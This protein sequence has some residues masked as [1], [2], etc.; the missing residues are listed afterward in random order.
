MGESINHDGSGGKEEGCFKESEAQGDGVTK[1]SCF[2]KGHFLKT[3][4]PVT[5][6]DTP[7]FGVKKF[8]DEYKHIED[9]VKLL[10]DDIKFVH[11]FV[12]AVK[13]GTDRFTKGTVYILGQ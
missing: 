13:E 11:V 6:I 9:L 5:F 4:E 10:R 1:A 7:G 3:G 2:K 12:L 8:S